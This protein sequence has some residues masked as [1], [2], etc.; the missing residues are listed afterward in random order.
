M[1]FGCVRS[2]GWGEM[3]DFRVTI[4]KMFAG[5]DGDPSLSRAM[6]V[7]ANL[8]LNIVK[9]SSSLRGVF[10]KLPIA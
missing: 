9:T 5:V 1:P 6:A 8:F 7:D 2:T 10:G 4:P 3:N